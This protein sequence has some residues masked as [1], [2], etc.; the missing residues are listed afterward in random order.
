MFGITGIGIPAIQLVLMKYFEFRMESVVQ[1]LQTRLEFYNVITGDLICRMIMPIDS[2]AELEAMLLAK[3]PLYDIRRLSIGYISYIFLLLT[4]GL[5]YPPLALLLL[6]SLTVQTLVLQLCIHNHY[7]QVVNDKELLRDW[8]QMLRFEMQYLYEILSGSSSLSFILSSLFVGFFVIDMTY[9][10]NNVSVEVLPIVLVGCTILILVIYQCYP[11][12]PTVSYSLSS[13]LST[14]V[15]SMIDWSGRSTHRLN[16]QN[17]APKSTAMS[18]EECTV[19]QNPIV[20]QTE[21]VG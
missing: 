10:S 19:I 11:H 3:T 12:V 5:G 15:I 13:T 8:N 7:Q 16:N 17:T 1:H 4:F 6:L 14:S 20:I 9:N 18:I 21:A 2:K